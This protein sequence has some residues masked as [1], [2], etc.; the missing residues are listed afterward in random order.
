MWGAECFIVPIGVALM[1]DYFDERERQKWIS[2]QNM[3]GAGAAALLIVLGGYY[4]EGNWRIP[5][6][7]YSLS[8][9]ILLGILFFTWEP[10][11]P[12]KEE[13]QPPPLPWVHISHIAILALVGGTL[14]YLMPVQIGYIMTGRGINSTLMISVAVGAGA[15]T[16]ALGALTSR[17]LIDKPRFL[18]LAAGM[19]LLGVG[20]ITMATGESFNVIL[21][22]ALIQQFGGGLMLPVAIN[23]AVSGVPQLLRGRIVGTWWF[24][25]FVATFMCPIIVRSS[26]V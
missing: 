22:G 21:T 16:S 5:F 18:V 4:A 3:I 2:Y 9:V 19:L 15:V 7:A 6:A 26:V 11:R 8:I 20:I 23:F 1:A 24:F 25:Y 14:F 17:I 13:I 10:K 12:K